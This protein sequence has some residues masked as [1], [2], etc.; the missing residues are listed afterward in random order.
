MWAV[1]LR[2]ARISTMCCLCP[3]SE[4]KCHGTTLKPAV[5]EQSFF[6]WVASYSKP[7]IRFA[8]P[9]GFF[10]TQHPIRLRTC[11]P[12]Q[13]C[14]A[15]Q[16][17]FHP[18]HPPVLCDIFEAKGHSVIIYHEITSWASKCFHENFH[19]NTPDSVLHPSSP[20]PRGQAVQNILGK[21]LTATLALD[22]AALDYAARNQQETLCL[23]PSAAGSQVKSM[24][25][26]TKH[27]CC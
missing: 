21:A 4:G 8:F 12:T 23:L 24:R 20:S 15:T 1:C 16:F 2:R 25:D 13:R 27:N 9:E 14:T 5:S 17:N 19:C 22:Y 7:P 18:Q 3:D 10:V 6:Q 11:P 26:R